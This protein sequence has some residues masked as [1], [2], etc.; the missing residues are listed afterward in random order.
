ME[1]RVKKKREYYPIFPKTAFFPGKP[2]GLAAGTLP[3]SAVVRVGVG[4]VVVRKGT[5]LLGR[6]R[7]A[8]GAGTWA[9]PGGHLEFGESVEAC[10]AREV[11]EET[12]LIIDRIRPETF[13]NDIFEEEAK[14]YITLFVSARSRTGEPRLREP[15]KCAEW[16]WFRWPEL[17]R[18]RFL[19]LA[20][21]MASGFVPRG[22]SHPAAPSPGRT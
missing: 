16:G 15:E 13:T 22:L 18:P 20:N 21:L 10:A 8:H 9:L 4:V 14:H 6:R 11:F 19:P 17:P 7:N 5:I 1:L 2:P 12:G 3:P